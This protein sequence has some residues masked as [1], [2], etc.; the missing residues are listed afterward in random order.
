MAQA[1]F[2]LPVHRVLSSPFSPSCLLTLFYEFVELV[3]MLNDVDDFGE[4]PLTK[5]GWPVDICCAFGLPLPAVA[6][7]ERRISRMPDLSRMLSGP[8][9]FFFFLL[10]TLMI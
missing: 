9:T 2:G 3:N 7:E 4:F 5:N 10:S 6:G 1:E 8:G